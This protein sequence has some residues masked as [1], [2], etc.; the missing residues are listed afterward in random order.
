VVRACPQSSQGRK[1]SW[2]HRASAFT[3]SRH[4]IT[5]LY[6][7]VAFAT[8]ID[9]SPAPVAHHLSARLHVARPLPPSDNVAQFRRS[10]VARLYWS[11]SEQVGEWPLARSQYS[12]ALA[13]SRSSSR[14]CGRLSESGPLPPAEVKRSSCVC[15]PPTLGIRSGKKPITSVS[16]RLSPPQIGGL[17]QQRRFFLMLWERC[18]HIACARALS[19]GGSHPMRPSGLQRVCH[20]HCGDHLMTKWRPRDTAPLDRLLRLRCRSQQVG[21]NPFECTGRFI[22]FGWAK[23][24]NGRNDGLV[25]PLEWAPLEE[26]DEASHD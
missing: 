22:G 4:T 5:P 18:P 24:E 20:R 2:P 19:P 11:S 26:Q 7:I 15:V 16:H 25:D 13:H 12:R 1:A 14:T 17:A 10:E 3:A 9:P 23:F 6:T 8:K 21:G